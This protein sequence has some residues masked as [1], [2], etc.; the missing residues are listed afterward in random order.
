MALGLAGATFISYLQ[1]TA[2]SLVTSPGCIIPTPILTPSPT[3]TPTLIPS[4][5][6]TYTYSPTPVLSPSAIST[7]FYVPPSQNYNQSSVNKSLEIGT[8]GPIYCSSPIP[9]SSPT[10]T[11]LVCPN[12]KL[13]DL[14]HQAL[15]SAL[16]GQAHLFV[17][18][19]SVHTIDNSVLEPSLRAA[20]V[21]SNNPARVVGTL[22]TS[23]A[24]T[25]VQ[26]QLSQQHFSENQ[27]FLQE[28]LEQIPEDESGNIEGKAQNE[29]DFRIGLTDAFSWDDGRFIWKLR[30]RLEWKHFFADLG[31]SKACSRKDGTISL[32]ARI[33]GK[34]QLLKKRKLPGAV[35]IQVT[36]E[37]DI[38]S[39]ATFTHSF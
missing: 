1:I 23:L 31:G 38:Q 36:P 7:N 24:Q 18:D 4:P 5:L 22:A 21:N 19:S 20:L 6:P 14:L 28:Q 32:E 15:D 25:Y 3:E 2:D 27:L 11:S 17:M 39:F 37:R 13:N 12:K 10:P 30:L 35:F 26:S 34:F 9:T 8:A 33:G 29:Q 16:K